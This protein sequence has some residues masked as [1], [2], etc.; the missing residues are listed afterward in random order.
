MQSTEISRIALKGILNK[1]FE[2]VPVDIKSNTELTTKNG[3]WQY[4]N[5]S[6]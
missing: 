2:N 5:E 6:I 1:Y 4:K 3:I